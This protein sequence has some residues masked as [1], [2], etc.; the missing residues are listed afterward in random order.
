[1]SNVDDLAGPA[2][3][4]PVWEVDALGLRAVVG[5]AA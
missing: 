5:G 2:L 3:N 4:L 1:M